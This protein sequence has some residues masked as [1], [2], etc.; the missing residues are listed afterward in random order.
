MALVFALGAYGKGIA[1]GERTGFVMNFP[2]TG[3]ECGGPSPREMS[4]MVVVDLD[5][6]GFVKRFVQPRVIEVAS[7]VVSNV[8]DEPYR[9]RFQVE[10]FPDDVELEYHSRDLA[11]NPDTHEIERDIAPG[12]SVDFG[13]IAHL[14]RELPG[15][16]IPIDASVV[17]VNAR[18]G[19]ELSRLPLKFV[20]EGASAGGSCCE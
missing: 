13:I 15:G 11:W 17:I 7:H 9:I 19:D 2:A 10:D 16:L 6:A 18:S 5:G 14:P 20:R 1:A 3:T 4:G 12:D 8:S